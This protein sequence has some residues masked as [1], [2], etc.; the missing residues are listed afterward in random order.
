M[1]SI[2]CKMKTNFV[3]QDRNNIKSVTYIIKKISYTK[4]KKANEIK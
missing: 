4:Y 3:I 2:N 1:I